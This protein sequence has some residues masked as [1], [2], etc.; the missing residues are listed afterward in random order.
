MASSMGGL[1]VGRRQDLSRQWLMRSEFLKPW[2]CR[3][4][5]VKVLLLTRLLSGKV[6]PR[7]A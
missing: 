7:L 5:E 3:D 4:A 1:G 6:S 2:V